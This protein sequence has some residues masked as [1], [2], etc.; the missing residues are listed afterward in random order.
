MHFVTI[1]STI[2]QIIHRLLLNFVLNF[3]YI[4]IFKYILVDLLPQFYFYQLLI[5]H[6]IVQSERKEKITI[7]NKKK[8][9]DF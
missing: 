9:T 2:K 7:K 5:F 6:L 8:F 1:G 4:S 3:N